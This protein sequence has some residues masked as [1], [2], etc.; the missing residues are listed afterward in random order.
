VR[1]RAFLSCATRKAG[2]HVLNCLN[3]KKLRPIGPQLWLELLEED[4]HGRGLA[5]LSEGNRAP[6]DEVQTTRL[7]ER[8]RL[9]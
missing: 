8:L 3:A 4:L 6:L 2:H 1:I 9:D 5:V 7:H